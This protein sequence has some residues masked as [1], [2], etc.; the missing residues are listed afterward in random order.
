MEWLNGY[1][2]STVQI[3]WLSFW[4]KI[5]C[6]LGSG[7]F[8]GPLYH[9]WPELHPLWLKGTQENTPVTT[10][11][12]VASQ[13]QSSGDHWKGPESEVLTE[14]IGKHFLEVKFSF[15]RQGPPCRAQWRARAR[16]EK[17]RGWPS[18]RINISPNPSQTRTRT[19]QGGES[20]GGHGG[21]NS[22]VCGAGVAASVCTAQKE[23]RRVPQGSGWVPL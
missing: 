16:G 14:A 3:K 19:Y 22:Y 21:R 5:W 15:C 6:P 13:Y 4:T 10:C 17:T 18:G 8:K 2:K 20:V 23:S 11:I 7:R 1:E 9:S 12:K